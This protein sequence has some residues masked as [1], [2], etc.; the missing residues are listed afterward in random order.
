MTLVHIHF[1][2][3]LKNEVG[4]NQSLYQILMA[5]NICLFPIIPAAADTEGLFC[6]QI[7]FITD[8]HIFYTSSSIFSRYWWQN[9]QFI[10]NKFCQ[11]ETSIWTHLA[12]ILYQFY[13]SR[14]FFWVSAQ[15]LDGNLIHCQ[16]LSSLEHNYSNLE[17]KFL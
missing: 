12:N 15:H 9:L 3:H 1:G 7:N 16:E 5:W 14:N 8:I 4:C 2:L 17:M 13:S 6:W 11:A 10:T